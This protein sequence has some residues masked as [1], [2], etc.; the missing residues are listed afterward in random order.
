MNKRDLVKKQIGKGAMQCFE[1]FGLDKT[2][3][4]DIAQTVGLNKAS[5]YYYYKNKEDIFIETALREGEDYILALQ[6]KVQLKKGIEDQVAY[7]M[8]ARFNYYK[9]VLNMNRVS[10][11]TLNKILPRFFE[12]YD[13]LM[14]REKLFLSELIRK[15]M[16]K[17]ELVQINPVKLA[18]VLIN[19]S[20]ALKHSVEQK[21]IL[22][23]E[24]DI[25]YARSLQDM[26]LLIS[27]IFRGLKK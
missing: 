22:K 12:L 19:I 6:E 8:Q 16:G 13:A 26:K 14:N 4:E 15:A 23:R 20:D 2:T 3:L 5:L 17:G 25:D 27:L 1:K 10:T 18:S 7:Y 21:A 24:P 11:D 9:K